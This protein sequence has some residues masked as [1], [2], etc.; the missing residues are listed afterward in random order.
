[1]GASGDPKVDAELDTIG[2]TAQFD[3][4]WLNLPRNIL[5]WNNVLWDNVL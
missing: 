2:H 4:A 3:T 1:M 5:P